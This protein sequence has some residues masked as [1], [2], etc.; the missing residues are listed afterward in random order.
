AAAAA[1]APA[2]LLLR[3]AVPGRWHGRRG[4]R[5][6]A[7]ADL[8]SRGRRGRAEPGV[9]PGL[10]RDV[11][12]G[13][14]A[15]GIG[16]RPVLGALEPFGLRLRRTSICRICICSAGSRLLP[17]P[18]ATRT[19]APALARGRLPIGRVAAGVSFLRNFCGRVR[20]QLA[21]RLV[22]E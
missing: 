21:R 9:L 17:P 20:D 7:V 11:V 5:G 4:R 19:A 16:R 18:T 6:T 1:A 22:L 14:A 15:G 10:F 2:P 13:Q 8:G 3:G 12:V